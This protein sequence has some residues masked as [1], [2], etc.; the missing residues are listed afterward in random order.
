MV[1]WCKICIKIFKYVNR[2][3]LLLADAKDTKKALDIV[4]LLS[5]NSEDVLNAQKQYITSM[6]EKYDIGIDKTR[7]GILYPSNKLE[8]FIIPLL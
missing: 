8:T 3:N 6:I 7:V 1:E 4:F 2:F 5:A